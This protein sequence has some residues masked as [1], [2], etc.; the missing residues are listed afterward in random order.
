MRLGFNGTFYKNFYFWLGIV[1]LLIT[2][3]ENVYLNVAY[4]VGGRGPLVHPHGGL[5]RRRETHPE[6]NYLW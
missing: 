2:V 1:F 4:N 5:Q 3:L 6:L